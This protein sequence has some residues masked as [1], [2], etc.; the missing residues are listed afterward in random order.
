LWDT[1]GDSNSDQ[2]GHADD[3]ESARQ[4]LE[5]LISM[6]TEADNDDRDGNKET[7][8]INFGGV[9]RTATKFSL[10]ELL[11]SLP[12]PP[13]SDLDSIK[14]PAAPPM[15]S[16]E[17][18]RRENEII[19]LQQLKNSD[20][21]SNEL[22]NLWYS[23]RGALGK[24]RLSE[25]DVIMGNPQRWDECEALLVRLIDGSYQNGG[26]SD[27]DGTKN[28]DDRVDEYVDPRPGI[29]FV[30][31]VNRLATL[32]FLQRRLDDSYKLCR[33]VLQLK[34]WHFGALSGI[35]QVCVALG[36]RDEARKW[37]ERRLPSLV[38]GRSFPGAPINADIGPKNPRRA[39]WCEIAEA[40][41][42]KLYF[43]AEENIV[44]GLG[45]PED[46]YLD[47]YNDKS[48]DEKKGMDSDV[49]AWQ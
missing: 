11:D 9:D 46:Y 2:D 10:R 32:Y 22:W 23:E 14:L 16:I 8:D 40:N 47:N 35:V 38:S 25:T 18:L 29:Y 4:K 24:K 42:R 43:L 3:V 15:S 44:Q 26:G 36:N 33:I 1:S 34:P 41:A 7:H 19:L 45:K 28:I 17:R 5:S 21:A 37:A 6:T 13:S 20:D 12:P 48:W 49:D 39:E 30:E 27:G 31:A